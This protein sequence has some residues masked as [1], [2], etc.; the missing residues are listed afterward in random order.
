MSDYITGSAA[1]ISKIEK[2]NVLPPS[3]RVIRKIARALR[4]DSEDL[5]LLAGKIP[6]RYASL[7]R[8]DPRIADFIRRANL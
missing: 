6:S 7:I 4:Y 1:Y 8:E 2:G 5:M 3:E